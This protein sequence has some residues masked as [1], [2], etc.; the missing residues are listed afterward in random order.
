M[1]RTA[2]QMNGILQS[3]PRRWKMSSSLASSASVSFSQIRGR[4]P[5]L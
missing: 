2:H 1:Y 4:F 5:S 3:I